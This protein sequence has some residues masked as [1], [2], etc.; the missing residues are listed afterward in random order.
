MINRYTLAGLLGVIAAVALVTLGIV[1]VG[2]ADTPA[3]QSAARD[4]KAA[5]TSTPHPSAKPQEPA[6]SATSTATPPPR[7]L[8]D[9]RQ[10]ARAA[11]CNVVPARDEGAEHVSRVLTPNDYGTNPPTS[12]PHAPVPAADGIYVAGNTPP[13][14]ALVHTLEHGRINIQYAPDTDPDTVA[15]LTGLFG[16]MDHGHHLLV[17]ENRTSMPF[18]VAATAWDHMLSCLKANPRIYDA[19]RAFTAE[20]VDQGPELVP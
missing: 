2:G 4:A 19:I 10:A 12:G 3:S 15:R 20:F 1:V 6:P 8:K 7:R 18:A 17:Y 13:L 9:L 5:D 14:G 16:Q 11:G